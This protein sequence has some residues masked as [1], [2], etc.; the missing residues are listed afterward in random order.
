[1][2]KGLF[3]DKD[4]YPNVY[5]EDISKSCKTTRRMLSVRYE[6]KYALWL[7]SYW[8]NFENYMHFDLKVY[9]SYI[10]QSPEVIGK[11]FLSQ[12]IR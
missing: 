10:K 5:F 7:K 11:L 8:A 3:I 12:L 2:T 1:M 4:H 9:S 6:S